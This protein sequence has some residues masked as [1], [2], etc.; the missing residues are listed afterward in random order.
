M[1]VVVCLL[2][3]LYL[4][5]RLHEAK[6]KMKEYIASH[7][8]NKKVKV[9]S[10]V[11]HRRHSLSQSSLV[12]DANND[13]SDKDAALTA[14]GLMTAAMI[15]FADEDHH[16]PDHD[17]S[18]D[19]TCVDFSALCDINPFSD[20]S[21]DVGTSGGGGGGG[22]WSDSGWSDF[23]GVCETS[24][25][26]GGGGGGGGTSDYG[27]GGGSDCGGGGSDCGGGGGSDCGGGGGCGG[28]CGGSDD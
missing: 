18:C 13:T 7:D 26:V 12:S 15:A 25:D 23:T 27:G 17:A 22:G 4:Q 21:G 5:T 11:R 10:R 9:R 20:D 16:H 24:T 28:G 6:T 3:M 1:N 19:F 14:T 2:F 8:L